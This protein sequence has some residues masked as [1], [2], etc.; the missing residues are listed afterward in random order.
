MVAVLGSI[1][2]KRTLPQS[3]ERP[4]LAR[5][6]GA[7]LWKKEYTA[8]VKRTEQVVRL[9]NANPQKGAASQEGAAERRLTDA[10]PGQRQP[11]CQCAMK[12]SA[13]WHAAGEWGQWTHAR[14]V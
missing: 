12:L 9:R 6:A 8:D 11:T 7:T 14:G 1:K 13:G 3:V 4:L 10:A 5:Y 2:R